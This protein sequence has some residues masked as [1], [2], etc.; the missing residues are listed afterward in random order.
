MAMQLRF[1]S[2]VDLANVVRRRMECI[3]WTA[4]AE[5]QVSQSAKRAD[6]VF[7]SGRRVMI[8]ETKLALS[9]EVVSQ[10]VRWLGKAHYVVIA[11]PAPKGRSS[12]RIAF[13]VDYLRAK[14]IGLWWLDPGEE[15]QLS[16]GTTYDSSRLSVVVPERL[17][18]WADWKAQKLRQVL[19]EEMRQAQAGTK[20]GGMASTPFKRTCLLLRKFIEEHS[21]TPFVAAM[22]RIQHHYSSVKSARS[23]IDIILKTANLEI[24]NGGLY[25]PGAPDAQLSKQKELPGLATQD[26]QYADTIVIRCEGCR[27]MLGLMKYRQFGMDTMET[28][29]PKLE[30]RGAYIEWEHSVNLPAL[31]LCGCSG[32]QQ[33]LL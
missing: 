1:K 17:H 9:I 7:E 16:S 10:A 2:E 22:E 27:G 33:I 4:Y 32:R 20:T 14:G 11:V 23:N 19:V 21:G 24:R 25:I 18:R 8:V 15:Q 12:E 5:V 29:R 31:S 30:K 6:L 3:G 26:S 13:I 28:I